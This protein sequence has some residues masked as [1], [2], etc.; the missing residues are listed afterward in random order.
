MYAIQ[1][2]RSFRDWLNEVPEPKLRARIAMRL[3]QAEAENL[4]DWKS[5]GA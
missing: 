5:L 4:G 3:R 2:T 1:L